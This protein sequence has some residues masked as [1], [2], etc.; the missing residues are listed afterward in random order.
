MEC[1]WLESRWAD[2]RQTYEWLYRTLDA[3]HHMDRIRLRDRP[4]SF[5]QI[6]F[7]Q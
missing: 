4:G 1:G 5:R 6:I 2:C 7:V 3:F